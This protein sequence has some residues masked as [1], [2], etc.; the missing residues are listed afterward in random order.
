M[1]RQLPDYLSTYLKFTEKS[2]PPTNYHIWTCL[3]VIA[4][5]MQRK[6][7][8]RWGFKTLYPNLYVVLIGP[9][10]CRKGTAMN[11]GKDLLIEINGVNLSSES[12]TREA[13]IRDMKDGVTTF[14]DPS[15]KTG[16]PL[17]FHSS[18]TVISEELSVFLGQQNVKFLAD[19]T[20]WF[21]CGDKWTYRTKGSGTDNLIGVCVNILG[22]TAPDWL[23]SILPQ[24]A[25][26]GG[27]T[28]RVIF[29][30]EESKKQI[31]PDPTI[32]PEILAL[33]PALIH[34][35]EQIAAM[36]GEMIFLE[37]TMEL[38][39]SWYIKQSKNSA[40]KDPHFAG[41]C[42]RR[43]TH[44]L[45]L[46]MVMSASRSCDRTI[47]PQ[48]FTRALALLESIEP[49]MS[50]AFMGL[51][52]AKYSE[53]TSALYEHLRKVHRA[54]MAELLDKFD[55]DLDEYTL[56]LVMKTLA[57]RKVIKI[58]YN[59]NNGEYYYTFTKGEEE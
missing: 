2:E 54:S 38:Y 24:E 49:K 16:N 47:Q 48:D 18:I 30:V 28:S 26:G 15:D 19:L 8:L 14:T 20:D 41:Y 33:R 39:T 43:A 12:V 42:E 22:A 4:A 11:I 21:D 10:G 32:P 36:A 5:A 29:V 50:R 25:F 35:L 58:E 51:G 23:R 17:K 40:I 56:Q 37:S 31:V 52:R 9:S 7:Y 34:D 45:K 1:I 6:C 57:A 27:F 46:S 44:V 3:S 55:T 53:M 13:L 59:S